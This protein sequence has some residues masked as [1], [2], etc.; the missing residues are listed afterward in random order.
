MPAG[1]RSVARARWSCFFVTPGTLLRWHRRL[2]AGRWTYPHHQAGRP[3]L[4]PQVRQLIAR[5]AKQ[6][7]RWGYQHMQG[8]LLRLGVRVSATAIRTTLRRHGL[9]PAPRRQSSTWTAFLP[10]QASGIVACDFLHRRQHLSET[11]VRAVLHRTGRQTGPSRR[12]DRQPRRRLGHP[13]GPQPPAG[14]GR[15]GPAAALPCL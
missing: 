9:D 13:A 3:P 10:Q 11:A 8:E 6:N 14:A 5:L 12:G 1:E 15:A 2:I 4:N 7:P